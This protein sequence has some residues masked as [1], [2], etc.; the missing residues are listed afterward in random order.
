MHRLRAGALKSE[1]LEAAEKASNLGLVATTNKRATKTPGRLRHDGTAS[2][3]MVLRPEE[4]ED[5]CTGS[6]GLDL[7]A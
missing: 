6:T 1:A 2:A 4:A 5:K 7:K 3:D